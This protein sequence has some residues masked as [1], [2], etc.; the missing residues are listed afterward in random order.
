MTNKT[1]TDKA[2]A[3][4]L[5]DHRLLV[6]RYTGQALEHTGL[7]V[8]GGTIRPG[9]TPAEAAVRE[10]HEET[11]VCELKLVTYLGQASYDITPLRPEVQ[12]R[13]YFHLAIEGPVSDRWSSKELHDGHQP[14]T[15][16]E[17]FWL[18]LT[19]GHALA[20]GHGALIHRLYADTPLS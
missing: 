13:H 5:N 16:L 4:I 8:P 19:Y 7:H 10:T 15:P 6:L 14:P 11:G 17:C 18:P 1:I 9:E 2:L 12:R 20:S 3:Y